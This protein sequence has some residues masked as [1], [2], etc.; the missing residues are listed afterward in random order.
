[1][2]ALR[3]RINPKTFVIT[4]KQIAKHLNIEPKR[5]RELGKMGQRAVGAY[6]RLGGY[7]VSYRKLEQWIAACSSLI[8]SCRD[9]KALL[10][11]R[12]AIQ[13]EVK[14]YTD[15]ALARLEEVWQQRSAY[16]AYAQT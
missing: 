15:V 5:M 2:T 11:V 7:F 16:L 14:R 3:R 6:P 9:L 10:L 1:M 13:K 8:R 12:W 4:L